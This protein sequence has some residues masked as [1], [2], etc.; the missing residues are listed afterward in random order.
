MWFYGSSCHLIWWKVVIIRQTSGI[1]SKISG[2]MCPMTGL[3]PA[4]RMRGGTL[5][6][7]G[8]NMWRWGTTKGFSRHDGGGMERA[9]MFSA[10]RRAQYG[11][12]V[13]E[14][15]EEAPQACTPLW[16]MTQNLWHFLL[17]STFRSVWTACAQLKRRSFC[18]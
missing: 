4:S 7:P 16:T 1:T 18:R 14:A 9:D 10:A 12:R 11:K 8:P 6:G 17:L 15:S 2:C 13:V 3:A 5:D